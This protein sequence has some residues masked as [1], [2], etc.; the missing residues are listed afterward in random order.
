MLLLA[1]YVCGG[2]TNPAPLDEININFNLNENM[3]S[4]MENMEN[5]DSGDGDWRQTEIGAGN[6]TKLFVKP[7]YGTMGPIVP[8]VIA[9]GDQ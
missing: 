9:R 7:Q 8:S 3:E 1:L 5:A 4:G 6:K 2:Q